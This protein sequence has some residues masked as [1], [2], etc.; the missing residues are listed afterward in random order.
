MARLVPDAPSSG[1]LRRTRDQF[2]Q[3]TFSSASDAASK[4]CIVCVLHRKWTTAWNTHHSAKARYVLEHQPHPPTLNLFWL[5]KCCQSFGEFFSTRPA[6]AGRFWGGGCLVQ[7]C[8]SRGVPTCD[9]QRRLRRGA[10]A[11]AP[12]LHAAARLPRLHRHWIHP[13]SVPRS[14]PPP[15]GSVRHGVDHPS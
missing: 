10:P 3:V 2:E 14:H 12:T 9:T 6:P 8:A 11:S 4:R 15:S 1:A 7:L 13:A 5:H